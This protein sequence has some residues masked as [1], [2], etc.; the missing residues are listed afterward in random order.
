MHDFMQSLQ[1]RW[2]V[3][4]HI[5]LS[6]VTIAKAPM[7]LPAPFA[8]FISEIFSSRGHPASGTPNTLDL[9]APFFSFQTGR[10][11]VL[12]LVVAFDAVVCLIERAG[13]I[14]PGIGKLKTFANTPVLAV[15]LKPNESVCRRPLLPAPGGADQACEEL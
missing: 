5:G 1:I 10:A 13:E 3:A 11:A 9:N 2:P 14:R 7:G 15:E 6:I 4:A 8:T 12:A